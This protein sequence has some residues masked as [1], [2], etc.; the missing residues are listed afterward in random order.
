[1]SQ[2]KQETR[3]NAYIQF[4]LGNYRKFYD[5]TFEDTCSH[6]S[7]QSTGLPCTF[8]EAGLASLL[9][10]ALLVE[11]WSQN[12]QAAPRA[13]PFEPEGLLCTWK[14]KAWREK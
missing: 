11:P 6:E 9:T 5:A 2:L 10:W 14:I 13:Q 12:T 3:E 1:M 8:L 4:I 7:T